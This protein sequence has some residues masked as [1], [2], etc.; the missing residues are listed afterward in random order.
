M[1]GTSRYPMARESLPVPRMTAARVLRALE[2]INKRTT[3]TNRFPV[4]FG[5]KKDH[6]VFSSLR[7]HFVLSPLSLAALQTT[8]GHPDDYALQLP[9]MDN[10]AHASSRVSSSPICPGNP[11]LAAR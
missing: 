3:K 5:R 1:P 9:A 8:Q 11:V 10:W 7:L 2:G 6:A 4:S